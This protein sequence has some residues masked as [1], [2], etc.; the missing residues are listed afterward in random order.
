LEKNV[1]EAIEAFHPLDGDLEG[2]L[3]QVDLAAPEVINLKLGN[4]IP[5]CFGT[6]RKV[7]E[8]KI[9]DS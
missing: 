1:W 9:P 2:L 5:I 6:P 8:E 7:T 3:Y 4:L